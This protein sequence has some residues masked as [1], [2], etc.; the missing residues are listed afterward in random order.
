M[1]PTDGW[2]DHLDALDAWATAVVAGARTGTS[3]LPVPT[4]GPEGGVPPRLRLRALALVARMDEA[5]RAVAAQ[6]TQLE[7]EHAYST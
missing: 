6:R 4:G 2:D 5:E 3:A 1:T 7:R